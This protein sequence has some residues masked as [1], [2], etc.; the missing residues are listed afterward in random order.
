MNNC[1]PTFW[2]LANPGKAHLLIL[3]PQNEPRLMHL[4][5]YCKNTMLWKSFFWGE[6]GLQNRKTLAKSHL[7]G[8]PGKQ[9][10]AAKRQYPCKQRDP[11]FLRLQGSENKVP[12]PVLGSILAPILRTLKLCHWHPHFPLE[13]F[14]LRGMY[15]TLICIRLA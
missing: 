1:S 9:K 15:P 7:G 12:F 10:T 4:P 3:S 11:H 2:H 13:D 5:S 14:F 6:A 8:P